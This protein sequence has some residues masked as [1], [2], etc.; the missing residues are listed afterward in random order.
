MGINEILLVIAALLPAIILLIYVYTKDRA[1][2]EPLHLLLLLL[3]A[4]AIII[5]PVV[6]IELLIGGIIDGAF[7]VTSDNTEALASDPVTFRIYSALTMFIG[8]ALIEEFFK[9]ISM[10]LITKKSKHFN[11]LFDGLIYAIFVSLGFAALENVFYVIEHGWGNAVMRAVLSVPGHMFFAVM[12][13]YFYSLWHMCDKARAYEAKFKELGV[14]SP[15]ISGFNSTSYKILSLI[16]PVVIHGFYNYCCTVGGILEILIMLGLIVGLYIF[17]FKKIRTMSA[18][19]TSDT[20]FALRLLHK[21]Y[22]AIAQW[23]SMN[24]EQYNSIIS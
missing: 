10:L 13:G 2:K 9:W 21:K 15:S 20:V 17:C 14:I 23:A 12:M 3:G 18:Q 1:E 22:P 11:S 7:G 4:G 5:L 6:I 24:P 19:D 16:V 8:V